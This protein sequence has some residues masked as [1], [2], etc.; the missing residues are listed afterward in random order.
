MKIVEAWTGADLQAAR[1]SPSVTLPFIVHG[2]ESKEAAI[3]GLEA[4]LPTNFTTATTGT[5]WLTSFR[6]AERLGATRY[7]AQAT[8]TSKKPEE[9]GETEIRFRTGGKTENI[10]VAHD[11][12]KYAKQGET[13]PDRHKLIGV[14]VEGKTV[15]GVDL[16][17]GVLEWE[18][19]HYFPIASLSWSFA[20]MLKD[21]VNKVNDAPFRDFPRGEVRFKG[22]DGTA[23]G[24]SKYAP[25]V[26][27]FEQSDNAQNL[28]VGQI[29]VE[30]K[31]GWD[32]L[33]VVSETKV[34]GNDLTMEP[35]YCYVN[36]VSPFRDFSKLGIGN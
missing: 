28:M 30:E 3:V 1:D 25:I 10:K 5:L 12:S 8:Y 36:K 21:F 11:Q 4:Y 14:D 33:E 2:A 19:T 9:P 17:V 35:K 16:P 24:R 29:E 13:A 23:K 20:R 6:V 15:R 32:Q 18:E 27:S 31:L 7:R 26:F 22:G 34:S